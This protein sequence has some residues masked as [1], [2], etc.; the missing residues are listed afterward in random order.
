MSIPGSA[1]S[2]LDAALA[3]KRIQPKSVH[4]T[5]RSR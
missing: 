1:A 4:S 5:S 3:D 2:M